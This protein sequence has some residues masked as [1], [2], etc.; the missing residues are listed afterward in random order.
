[1]R[2]RNCFTSL[3][4]GAAACALMPAGA[5]A[6]SRATSADGADKAD[7]APDG[8][9][10]VVTAQF[11]RE[12]SQKAAVSL[13]VLSADKLV[14][15]GVTQAT[16]IARIAPGVQIT[17]GGSALQ[18]YIRGAGDFSTTSYSNAA[19]AQNY[20]GVFASRTQFVANTFFDLERIEVLK[21][22]QGTL[23]GRNATGGALNIIPVQPKLGETSGYLM[24]TVQNYDGYAAEGAINLATGEHSALRFSFQGVS[25]SGYISDGTDDDK[26]I[27][28]RLQ[29]KA[30]PTDNLTVR[31]A[32]NYQHL[33]GR[34][35]GQVVYQVTPAALPGAT[36]I[37]PS[38]RW[39][40]I[41]D[42]LNTYISS[43][44]APPGVYRIDTQTVRQDLDIWGIYAHI[45]WDLGPATLTVIPAYQRVVNASKSIPTLNFDTTDF[46]SKAPSTSN[47]ESL[48][49][50][51]ANQSGKVSWVLG[52]YFFNEDQNS[53]NSVRLGFVSDTDF[54]AQLNNK[55]IAAFGQ[56]TYSIT[57]VLRLTGGLRY[58]HE[59]KSV[60][61]DRYVIPGSLGCTS[62][63]G[64]GPGGSC[65][66]PHISGNYVA[67]KINYK[68]GFEFDLAPRSM[69][70]ANVATG[71]KS[72]GQVNAN[73]PAYLPEDL[74]AYTI[75]SKNRFFGDVLQLNAEL[76]WIDYRNHQENFSTLDRSGAQVQAL[77]NAGSA[78]SR[79]AAV[80]VILRPTRHDTLA[81][82]AE[83][84]DGTYR[85]FHYNT[86]KAASPATSTGCPVSAIPGGTAT[87]GLWLVNCDGFQMARTPKWAGSAS[88]THSFEL[89]SGG[90]VD[91][92][93][94]MT[95]ASSRWIEA[96]FVSND[97]TAAYQLY[98]ASITYKS[99]HDAL[100]IQAFVRNIG[101]T[102]V[103]TGGQQYPFIANYVGRDVGSPRTYGVRARIGF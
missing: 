41:N 16:D 92:S 57:D 32:G 15:S 48:E 33:G 76:F 75:G 99:P 100:M 36:A 90:S 55:G 87:T 91:I 68:A 18:I 40:S 37:V 7:D 38:D 98:N 56:L 29:F 77:L 64:T 28:V 63:T 74:T 78:R 103:Y 89:D 88:Y 95:F 35:H 26:H 47:T 45:D 3:M 6:Q 70:F 94:D 82:A 21:G 1:M 83:Y 12:S 5:H 43:L 102:A 60:S 27:S 46:F 53:N 73:L 51:L 44:V 59:T 62:G 39:T 2:R 11:R 97:R 24:G 79:G 72:G 19:V 8:N 84:T 34:G 69:L 13:E 14:S 30:Q 31:L 71:F 49:A 50:R 86:Y 25:R 4:I 10:V 66:L 20:D 85:E 17:Q 65:V 23:Y 67:N 96:A 9:E 61:A 101:N 58:T 80:D 42:S 22:P 54:V 93:G 52:G 81:V